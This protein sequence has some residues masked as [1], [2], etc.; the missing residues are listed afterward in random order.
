MGS[1]IK[2]FYYVSGISRHGV[3]SFT[4]R[5]WTS[6]HGQFVQDLLVDWDCCVVVYTVQW[7]ELTGV[8]FV[9]LYTEYVILIY[10]NDLNCMLVVIGFVH[11]SGDYSK[12]NSMPKM[13]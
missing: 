8:L 4:W 1:S 6:C 9:I 13:L 2:L 7:T 5:H 3:R 10:A 12:F 11:R